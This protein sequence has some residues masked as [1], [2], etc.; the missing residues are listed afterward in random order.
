MWVGA[1]S[2]ANVTDSTIRGN[3][4]KA[5]GGL[6]SEWN[7]VLS[8]NKSTVSENSAWERGGGLSN[9]SHATLRVLNSTI[10]NNTADI[11]G[12]GILA[13]GTHTL[14]KDSTVSGNSAPRGGG[15]AGTGGSSMVMT[16]TIAFNQ[17]NEIG[18]GVVNLAPRPFILSH[19]L[20]TGN[21]AANQ[22]SEVHDSTHTIIANDF[23]LFGHDGNAALSGLQAGSNDIV[24][25]SSLD[26]ILDTELRD[27]GGPTDTHALVAGSQ[28]ID[29][30][31]PKFI[32]YLG[33]G[34]GWM[35]DQR[36]PDFKRIDS[37]SE[38]VD[39]GAFEAQ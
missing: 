25:S 10:I 17:A 22:P 4:G 7:S 2:T 39:I 29:S 34:G 30:G 31:D 33:V 13:A 23:N 3:Y 5:G 36:G 6:R 15:I 11:V 21:T 1:T 38:L 20:I 37:D 28:A 24:A 35:Y 14:V 32:N 12:G 16:S 27:N 19:A 18:G 26:A 8:V 9:G